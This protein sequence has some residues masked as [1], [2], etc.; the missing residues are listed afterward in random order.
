MIVIKEGERRNKR[1]HR[2]F[3]RFISFYQPY[4]LFL[5]FIVIGFASVISNHPVYI[6]I[7]Y[8]IDFSLYNVIYQ[9]VLLVSMYN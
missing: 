5:D 8:Y 1:S 9:E 7:L 2:P 4:L 6:Y 3:W